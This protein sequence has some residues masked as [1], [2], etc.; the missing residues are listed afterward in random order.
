M[1]T[2]ESEE[3]NKANEVDNDFNE[4]DI[5]TFAKIAA[6]VYENE[7][8]T[9]EKK[10]DE[11]PT[12][13][14]DESIRD[15]NNWAQ[16]YMLRPKG[17]ERNDLLQMENKSYHNELLPYFTKLQ[18]FDRKLP[19]LKSYSYFVIYGG[20]PDKVL[21]RINYC[22]Y[23]LK[24]NY[25]CENNVIYVCGERPCQDHEIEYLKTIGIN[26][27]KY[28]FEQEYG[29]KMCVDAFNKLNETDKIKVNFKINFTA[30]P[31]NKVRPST[32][33]TL[34]NL[35]DSINYKVTDDK[36]LSILFI[37]NSPYGSYQESVLQT[38][39]TTVNKNKQDKSIFSSN[40]VI[41][42]TVC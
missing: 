22:K 9:K 24:N 26:D 20:T 33:D 14:N 12:E 27:K 10:M 30:K 13:D 16:K 36:Q 5:K 37:S 21:E 39:I 19:K 6:I 15:W 3:D 28:F 11:L 23:L 35:F 25:I 17:L 40:K 41:C 1:A 2:K 8:K 29:E 18:L 4:F 38:F 31:Q 7:S 34:F 32:M 42:D